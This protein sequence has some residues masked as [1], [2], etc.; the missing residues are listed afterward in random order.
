MLELFIKETCP[1]CQKVMNYLDENGFEYKKIDVI[2]KLNEEALIKIGGKSQVPFLM[3]REHNIEMY[4][5]GD[6]LEYLK[7][8]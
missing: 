2:N 3:D 1:Y 6:I 4:E 5:S 7:T 8:L